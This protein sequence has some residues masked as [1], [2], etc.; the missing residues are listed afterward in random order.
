MTTMHAM[1]T[2]TM[3]VTVALPPCAGT[4]RVADAATAPPTGDDDVIGCGWYDSSF[5]LRHGLDV[6]ELG[7]AATGFF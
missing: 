1:G 4:A 7:P 3:R 2:A 5:E 6:I